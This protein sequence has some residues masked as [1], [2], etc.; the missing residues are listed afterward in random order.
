[1][2]EEAPVPRALLRSFAML[3]VLLA[4]AALDQTIVSTAL[5]AITHDLHGAGRLSWVFSAYLIASTVAVPMYG[6]LADQHGTRPVLLL[7]VALFLAGSLLCGLAQQMDAL[8]LARGLQGAGGGGFLTLAMTSVAR[9]FAPQQRGRLQGLLG[10]TY[11]LA[12]MAGPVV[13]GLMVEHLSWRWAFFIN[14]PVG[15]LALAMLALNHPRH[16]PAQG[17]AMDYRGAALLS[18][19]LVCVMLSTSRNTAAAWPASSLALAGALLGGLFLWSQTRVRSPLLPLSLF[20][21]RAFAGTAALS[22]ASGVMLFAV[23]VF[24]PLYLQSARGLAPGASGWHLMPLMAGITLAS[25]ACGRVLSATGRVRS[26]ATA[27]GALAALS[28]AL[29]GWLVRDATVPV[30]AI[31]AC[32]VPLGLGL[33]ALFPVVTVVVQVSAPPPLLGI[34][35]ASPVMFRSVAGAV[36]VS[37]LGVLFSHGMAAASADTPGASLALHYGAAFSAV[38][39]AAAGVSLLAAAASLAL[40]VRLPPRPPAAVAP[41]MAPGPRQT[42]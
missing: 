10:A 33:G 19:A 14:L 17:V 25:I 8:I 42:A 9:S 23:V 32:L 28:F 15:L 38:L 35:T 13:G 29:L 1:M 12:T 20:R 34:A 26:V 36:G 22:S 31:S 39:W 16:K 11:G 7:A 5:P 21:Q 2:D 40:P 24:M 3:L 41:S 37:L 6:K 30:L 27:A 18:A 4:L